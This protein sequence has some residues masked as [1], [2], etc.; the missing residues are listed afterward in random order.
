MIREEVNQG[1]AGMVMK[2][3]TVCS[4]TIDV[5]AGADNGRSTLSG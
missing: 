1:K 5:P 4:W 3:G 2:E